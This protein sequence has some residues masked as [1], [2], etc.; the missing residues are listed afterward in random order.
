MVAG[1]GGGVAELDVF[2]DVR[3][4]EGD[5]AVSVDAGHGQIPIGGDRV[6]GPVVAVTNRVA[7]RGAEESLVASGRDDVADVERGVTDVEVLVV[8]LSEREA[9]GLHG[10]VDGVDVV[11]GWWL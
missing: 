7:G 2:G 9:V 8:E 5:G 1:F 11:V 10:A 6:D 3:G 4:G